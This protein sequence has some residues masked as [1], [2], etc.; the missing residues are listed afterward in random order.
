MEEHEL[1]LT[2]VFVCHHC[3]K[4]S[5]HIST[6]RNCYGKSKCPNGCPGHFVFKKVI[7][8]A[9]DLEGII[10]S[11]NKSDDGQCRVRE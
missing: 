6:D 1:L 3:G 10:D 5:F 9:T 11:F 4:E 2:A 8:L 7:P